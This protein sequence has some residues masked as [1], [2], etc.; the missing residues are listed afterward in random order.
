M[1]GMY[2]PFMHAGRRQPSVSPS[3]DDLFLKYMRA[4]DWVYTLKCTCIV[5]V[6]R[7][8]IQYKLVGERRSSEECT[9][10]TFTEPRR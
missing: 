4:S 7:V 2:V 1:F 10:I 9:A 3:R 6:F 5:L 8:L